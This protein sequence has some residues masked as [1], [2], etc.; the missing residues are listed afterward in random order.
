MKIPPFPPASSDAE[1]PQ[2]PSSPPPPTRARP[3]GAAPAGDRHHHANSMDFLRRH[4][5]GADAAATLDP[6][7]ARPATPLTG[8][9]DALCAAMSATDARAELERVLPAAWYRAT[10]LP[11]APV[12][13]RR[14]WPF[15]IGE[16][17]ISDARMDCDAQDGSLRQLHL[18]CAGQP[19][20][21][22]LLQEKYGRGQASPAYQD[23][24]S[25]DV[26][27]SFSQPWG[28]LGL[29]ADGAQTT[30]RAI[31]LEPNSDRARR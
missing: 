5:R 11:G 1:Q 25:D 14:A 9:T 28:R 2:A 4:L 3:L 8:L 23:G 19:L 22:A 13:V 6:G 12:E 15:T 18:S 30:C 24:D 27:L 20:D 16:C 21:L 31:V 17:G 29:V 7:T 26:L 10:V